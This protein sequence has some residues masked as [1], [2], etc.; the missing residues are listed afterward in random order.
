ML[1]LPAFILLVYGLY[2]AAS[3]VLRL[4]Y[5]DESKSCVDVHLRS[6][7]TGSA[8]PF[9]PHFLEVASSVLLIR[10]QVNVVLQL[11]CL[12]CFLFSHF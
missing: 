12:K 11:Y 3:E 1:F 7:V 5:N 10:S 8:F 9:L 4:Q 6:E 2:C